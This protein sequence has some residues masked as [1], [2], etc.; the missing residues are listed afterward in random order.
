MYANDQEKYLQGDSSVLLL[1][2]SKADLEHMF[3]D[4]TVFR[5]WHQLPLAVRPWAGISSLGA[6]LFICKMELKMEPISVD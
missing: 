5:S 3:C 2:Q 6:S 1:P 4:Q